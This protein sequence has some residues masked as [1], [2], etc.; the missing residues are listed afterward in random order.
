MARIRTIKPEFFTSLTIAD[1]PIEVRLTFIGLWTHVDDQGRCVDDARLV[2]AALWPLDDRTAAE[3]GKDLQIL[4]EASLITRYKVGER[5]YL[6]VNSWMEHQRINRPSRSKIPGLESSTSIEGKPVTHTYT[7]SMTSDYGRSVDAHEHLTEDSWSDHEQ[8]TG[9]KERN[10]EQGTGNTSASD[11]RMQE[12]DSFT[13]QEPLTDPTFEIGSDDDPKWR[14]LW[15]LAP[16]KQ[17]KEEA[18]KAYINHVLGTGTYEGRPIAK[19]DPDVIITGMR[20]YA[21]RVKRERTERKHIKM[22]Q[23]WLNGR[24]WEDEQQQEQ[25]Q[26][27]G[28]G[29]SIWD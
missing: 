28:A 17:G 27:Q 23:G 7:D 26:V 24:R 12:H 3:I 13:L 25:H 1:L 21:D 19:T 16:R 18:R 10:R 4:S 6:M 11:E 14:E 15:G 29:S 20:A 2:K 8:L 5:S 9:G 22:P